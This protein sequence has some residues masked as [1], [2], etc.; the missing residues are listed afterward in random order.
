MRTTYER[1]EKGPSMSASIK[2][3][4]ISLN[5]KPDLDCSRGT[6]EKDGWE[7]QLLIRPPKVRIILSMCMK[8][9]SL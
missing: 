1:E 6:W 8:I 7:L 2:E 9:N 3:N 4:E 5:F